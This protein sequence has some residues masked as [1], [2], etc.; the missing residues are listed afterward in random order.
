MCGGDTAEQ[1]ADVTTQLHTLGIVGFEGGGFKK[2]VVTEAGI[3][4]LKEVTGAKAAEEANQMAREQLEKEKATAQQERE[5]ARAQTAAEQLVASRQ[6]GGVRRGTVGG[7]FKS[8][9]GGDTDERDF[10][11][12]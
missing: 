9:F 2:G 1:I 6:A 4:G 11:G 5:E 3:S 7:S 10:L 12:L 8:S